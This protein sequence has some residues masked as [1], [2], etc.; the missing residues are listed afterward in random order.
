MQLGAQQVGQRGPQLEGELGSSV[1]GDVCWQAETGDP[2]GEQGSGAGDC[3]CLA[4]RYRLRPP[5]ETVH[6]GQQV[7]VTLGRGQ[8]AH[9]V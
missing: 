2:L 8:G 6:H 5:G 9:N 1:G 7:G 3:V 4:E